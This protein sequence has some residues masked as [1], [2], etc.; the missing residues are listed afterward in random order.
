M[1]KFLGSSGT[2]TDVYNSNVQTTLG[3]V[4][5][6]T[7]P[8]NLMKSVITAKNAAGVYENVQSNQYGEL[9]VDSGGVVGGDQIT[10]QKTTISQ[11]YS[12]YGILNDQLYTQYT[13]SGGTITPTGSEIDM[14]I[15]GTIYSY[16]TLRGKRVI[17]HRAGV[18]NCCRITNQFVAPVAS[19]LQFCGA[20]NASSDIYF[21]Y[22][23]TDFGIRRSTGGLN[24]VHT[25]TITGA[26]TTAA[27][28]TITLNSVAYT[29]SL[30][31]A[32]TI[33]DFTAHECEGNAFGGLWTVDHIGATV[34]FT[35]VGVGP[36][37]GTY[38]YSSDQN[39]TG[40]FATDRVG[41]ALTTTFVA[42]SAWN[43][44]SSLVVDPLKKNM[45]D[46]EWGILA[47]TIFKV[48]NPTTSRYET[49]HTLQHAN[50]ATAL[51]LSSINMFLQAG[52][53]SL[54]STT[55]MGA[56]VLT[57]MYSCTFGK[58]QIKE[59]NYSASGEK[60]LS[61]NTEANVVVLKVRDSINGY[62]V[63]SE[64]HINRITV[65]GDG[66]QAVVIKLIRSPATVGGVLTTDYTDYKYVNATNSI[67]LY[68]TQSLIYT[69]G[70]LFDTF[71]V[72][73]NAGLI[74]DKLDIELTQSEILVISAESGA[75]N[76]VDIS[77]SFIED[78]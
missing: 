67:M 42:Q 20:G 26:E 4:E 23:G 46:I 36:R 66:N 34:V 11:L 16:A 3:T 53:A 40:T 14:N 58:I 78:Q 51:P 5:T 38:S 65:S 22:N 18:K 49:V 12:P 15:T 48:Y 10:D 59:P 35:A 39:S 72:A 57:D 76:T 32:L 8:A 69:G 61:S 70:N 68:D 75:A 74:I 55:A 25:L 31:N 7:H 33:I 63:K 45:Y 47:D 24:E 44:T 6:D 28:A 21:C 62:S 19:S 54:G 77:V 43:G 1:N 71:Y 73:K 27:T 41:V 60:V 17:K 52:L 2:A 64:C 37:T 56:M 29:V 30:T 13:G 50:T 9:L